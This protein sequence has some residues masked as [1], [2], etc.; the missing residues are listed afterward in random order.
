MLYGFEQAPGIR[1]LKG[2]ERSKMLR[3]KY[4]LARAEHL[5]IL[6]LTASDPASV[7]RLRG[8]VEK[9]R[10][11]AERSKKAEERANK[12]VTSPPLNSVR[13]EYDLRYAPRITIEKLPLSHPR[14]RRH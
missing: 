3:S 7:V 1:H 2:T 12:Q 11:L 9:Y 8:F 14:E 13:I 10:V 4:C 5:R 6:M